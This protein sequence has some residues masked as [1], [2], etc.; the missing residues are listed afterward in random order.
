VDEELILAM[1][2]DDD[3]TII[4]GRFHRFMKREIQGIGKSSLLPA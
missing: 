1:L 3:K 2:A 4:H